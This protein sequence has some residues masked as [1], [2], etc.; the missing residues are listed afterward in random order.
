MFPIFFLIGLCC[1][2][3]KGGY[4]AKVMIFR[5]SLGVTFC[6]KPIRLITLYPTGVSEIPF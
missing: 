5:W 6:A 1:D 3:I 2:D 4:N